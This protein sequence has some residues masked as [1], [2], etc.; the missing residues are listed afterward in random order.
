MGVHIT[1]GD[2]VGGSVTVGTAVDDA[3]GGTEVAL[4]SIT[5]VAESMARVEVGAGACVQPTR[6]I[7]KTI[8]DPTILFISNLLI[9]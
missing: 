7:R 8:R 2:G 4:G 9:S 5:A 6:K 1:V 3:M